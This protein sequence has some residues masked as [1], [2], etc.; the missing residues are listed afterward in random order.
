MIRDGRIFINQGNSM[1]RGRKHNRLSIVS[2]F[3]R[4]PVLLLSVPLLTLIFSPAAFAAGGDPVS[5]FPLSDQQIGKQFS[6]AMAID[7]QGN[8]IVTGYTVTTGTND[9]YTVKFKADGTGTAWTALFDKANSDDRAVAVVV[10]SN[11][12]VL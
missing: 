12:D 2:S 1:K 6:E 7:S 11:N 3:L 8:A 5:P 9:F 4:V 10:D